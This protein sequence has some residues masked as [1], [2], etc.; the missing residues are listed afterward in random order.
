MWRTWQKLNENTLRGK[1]VH[2]HKGKNRSEKGWH[3]L[4]A[5]CTHCQEAQEENEALQS[6]IEILE[7]MHRCIDG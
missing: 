2:Q 7:D 6:R 3:F 1:S 5:K 4:L